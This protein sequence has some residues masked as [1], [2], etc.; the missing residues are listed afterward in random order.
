MGLMLGGGSFIVEIQLVVKGGERCCWVGM[1]T[2]AGGFH[3]IGSLRRDS[4]LLGSRG[5]V[6]QANANGAGTDRYSW[7]NKKPHMEAHFQTEPAITF[8][9]LWLHASHS[10]TTSSY[11]STAM[12]L[13]TN[14][15][16]LTRSLAESIIYGPFKARWRTKRH[17]VS[18]S[19]RN[20]C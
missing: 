15:L 18:R 5:A 2:M 16:H 20:N 3:V 8:G 1:H 19:D 7:D 9:I 6:L 13:Y 4:G 12:Y 10:C 11:W 14:V 17:S